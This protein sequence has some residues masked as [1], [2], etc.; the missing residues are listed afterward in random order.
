MAEDIA[1]KG[2]VADGFESVR[3]AFAAVAAEEG[4]SLAAH[5]GKLAVSRR[6]CL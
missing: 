2:S 6:Q 3:A 5:G 1:I 4:M